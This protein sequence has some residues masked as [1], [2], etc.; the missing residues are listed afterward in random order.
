MRKRLTERTCLLCA[1]KRGGDRYLLIPTVAEYHLGKIRND[2]KKYAHLS[3]KDIETY[4]QDISAK[5]SLCEECKKQHSLWQLALDRPWS[6]FDKYAD[7]VDGINYFFCEK[8]QCSQGKIKKDFIEID[9]K[10]QQI[11]PDP[12][13]KDVRHKNLDFERYLYQYWIPLCLMRFW[14]KNKVDPMNPSE[15]ELQTEINVVYTLSTQEFIKNG[16]ITT[17]N[18]KIQFPILDDPEIENYILKTVT[19][20]ER[21]R[22]ISSPSDF[23]ENVYEH[24]E[25]NTL[26]ED[27]FQKDF[28]EE[29]LENDQEE[30]RL[31]KIT[32]PELMTKDMELEDLK[33]TLIALVKQF[34]NILEDKLIVAKQREA[35]KLRS[36]KA[37]FEQIGSEVEDFLLLSV[38]RDLLS[39]RVKLDTCINCQNRSSTKICKTKL[40]YLL[41]RLKGDK[42]KQS[43]LYSYKPNELSRA[44]N[45]THSNISQKFSELMIIFKN[46]M[47]DYLTNKKLM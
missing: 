46:F 13:A 34:K 31:D 17:G 4:K 29:S 32:L 9:L 33:E 38:Q 14:I 5:I 8:R 42:K 6:F 19:F 25:N 11:R 23:D 27:F 45:C 47:I 35:L 10:A 30:T 43:E 39:C 3:I 28:P 21:F 44:L 16:D 41:N 22:I 36:F 2:K 18:K 37:I 24:D 12:H 26:T 20:D 40:Q 7:L 15:Q 1:E